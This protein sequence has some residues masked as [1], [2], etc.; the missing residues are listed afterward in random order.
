MRRLLP[1]IALLALAACNGTPPPYTG[2]SV[3]A[4]TKT[5]LKV[6]DGAEAKPGMEVLVNYTGWLYDEKAADKH[7]AKF[8]SSFDHG[9]P[10]SFVL[11]QG[12]VIPGWDQGVAGMRVGG[13]RELLIPAELG[14]GAR[15][16]GGG[17]IP[18]GASLVFEVELVDADAP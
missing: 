11:G 12:Q 16:A 9:S 18:P 5:D 3:A 1:L 15:G 13:K 7:G 8:D 17:V 6:G 14:Y 4:L 2:G 10:F